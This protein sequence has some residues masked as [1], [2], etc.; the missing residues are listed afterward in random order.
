[1]I[2]LIV[3]AFFSTALADDAPRLR[4]HFGDSGWSIGGW[5]HLR[6]IVLSPPG[7]FQVDADGNRIGQQ[8]VLDQRLR[9]GLDVQWKQLRLATEWDLLTG[10]LAGDTWAIP[11]EVD[12]RRRDAR[13]ALT[14]EGFTP[15]RLSLGFS[16]VEDGISFEA[17][18]VTASWGLGLLANS[19][20]GDSLFGRSDRG[21]RMVRFR[22]TFAPFHRKEKR[23]PIYAT[24]AF[25][26]VVEDD[27][28]KL[29]D[30][31]RGYQVIAS[32]LYSDLEARRLG[33][34]FTFRGQTEPGQAKRPTQA[35]VFDVYGDVPVDLGN[36]WKLRVA[37]EF[38]GIVGGTQKILTYGNPEVTKVRSAGA[39]VETSVTSPKGFA[40]FHL[41]GGASS[42]TGDADA[43][44]LRDFTFD[45]N[46][47]VGLV[48]FDEVMGS[49]EAATYAQLNNPENAGRP[50][51]GADMLVSEGS[52]RR[53][54]YLQP[55]LVLQPFPWL[56]LRVGGVFGWS[57]GPISQAFYTYRAGGEPRNHLNQP[58][59]GRFLGSEFDWAVGIGRGMGLAMWKVRPKLL[60]EGG[61]AYLSPDLGGGQVNSLMV[62]AR[63]DW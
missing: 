7:D 52:V 33:F 43:G 61:H 23:L 15:R 62:T 49:I 63:A 13:L 58:T 53:A 8:L 5:G 18:L 54:G 47:N 3:S 42:A 59:E 19:G 6:E 22:T 12:Q 30:G 17:G 9:A 21:D 10:Q 35:A 46:Y 50:P 28:A 26:Q 41:R 29:S 44:V 39:A 38:A 57:T 56:D 1:M 25:D 24:V 48:L 34:F 45:S 51:Y 31:Q 14:G 20:G 27:L 55:A 60:I 16:S 2:S 40:T 32:L 37:G 4:H 36:D 11:G